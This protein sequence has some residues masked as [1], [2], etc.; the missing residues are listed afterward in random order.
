MEKNK[1][2]L[3][4]ALKQLRGFS[5]EEVVWENI[6]SELIDDALNNSLSKLSNFD[7]HESVWT[8][9][10]R[11]L[12]KQEK[13]SQL[14]RFTPEENIWLGIEAELSNRPSRTPLTSLEGRTSQR[15]RSDGFP[16]IDSRNEVKDVREQRGRAGQFRKNRLYLLTLI[17]TAA[18]ILFLGYFVATSIINK[19]NLNYTEEIIELNPTNDWSEEDTDISTVLNELCK[20]NP[21]A[22]SSPGFKEKEKELDYLNGQKQEVLK[23]MTAWDE[24]ED[25]QLILTKIELEKNEIIKQMISTII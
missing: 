23:R 14:K 3:N 13:I 22:C 19:N 16:F 12:S 9:I 7:P 6:K 15:T 2:I 18:A 5:P 20:T 8:D 10:S 21:L 11:E 24:N 17:S 1:H 25:L 4:D